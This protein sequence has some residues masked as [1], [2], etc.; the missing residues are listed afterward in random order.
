MT[1]EAQQFRADQ[2]RA[3]RQVWRDLVDPAV[4]IEWTEHLHDDHLPDVRAWLE[5]TK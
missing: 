1:T 3:D 5:A 2:V 4:D